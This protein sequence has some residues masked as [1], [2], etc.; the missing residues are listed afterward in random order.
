VPGANAPSIARAGA[1]DYSH[2]LYVADTGTNG[3]HLFHGRK[4]RSVGSITKGI[5]Y[6]VDVFLDSHSN[7]YV[8]NLNAANV[9]EYAPGNTAFPVFTYTADM[10]YPSAVTTD[11]KGHLFEGEQTGTINE[12]DVDANSTIAV[13]TPS[14]GFQITGLGVDRLDDVFAAITDTGIVEY[15]GG[16]QP[17][18]SE[19][20]LPVAINPRG[21]AL[22]N[23]GNLVV[24]AGA[25]V[26][27]I[28]APSYDR[29][30]STIG[31]GFSC[32]ANVRLN[33][34]NTLAFVSDLCNNTVTVVRYPSGTN[35]TVLGGANGLVNPSAA[36][37]WPNAVY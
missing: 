16:L 21:I 24:A 4:Y 7:L 30:T 17:S 31:S 15:T 2:D 18:C 13:C 19:K 1:S 35:V 8:A 10:L 37:D 6:P 25:A 14:S 32:A 5:D 9:V 20:S 27:V 28:D 23:N 26:D 12:Y 3:I 34:A 33:K 11:Q 36:V 29:V 22:D